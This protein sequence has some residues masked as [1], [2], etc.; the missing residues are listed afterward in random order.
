[1]RNEQKRKEVIKTSKKKALVSAVFAPVAIFILMYI[2][3]RS[4]S[5]ITV[6]IWYLF[7]S[8]VYATRK[9]KQLTAKFFFEDLIFVFLFLSPMILLAFVAEYIGNFA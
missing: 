1:M 4:S 5:V 2:V 9:D 3:D 8:S 6:G 7:A